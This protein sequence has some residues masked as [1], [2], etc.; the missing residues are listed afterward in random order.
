MGAT[1]ETTIAQALKHEALRE[2]LLD[3]IRSRRFRTGDLFM[4]QNEIAKD[5][6]V[7]QT[8]VVRALDALRKE[9]YLR[10]R[11]GRGT[12]VAHPKSEAGKLHSMLFVGED[13]NVI[14][15]RD[16]FAVAINHLLGWAGRNGVEV[17]YVQVK[18][19]RRKRMNLPDVTGFDG[20]V[21]LGGCFGIPWLLR[22]QTD[23]AIVVVRPDALNL[24][25]RFDC[26]DRDYLG[27]PRAVLAHLADCG[28]DR[29]GIVT[30]RRLKL[31]NHLRMQ[32]TFAAVSEFQ[33]LVKP[34]WIVRGDFEGEKAYVGARDL[35]R[36][37]DRPCAIFALGDEM[38]AGVLRAANELGLSVPDD[39][40]VAGFDGLE[41]SGHLS[42]PLTCYC[43]D[44][45]A[46][47]KKTADLLRF[48]LEHPDAQPKYEPV[49]GRML[50]RQSTCAPVMTAEPVATQ[51]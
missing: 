1:T 42:P 51:R 50:I 38:A 49:P 25:D 48:R 30:G 24:L 46:L 14:V 4:S 21:V 2:S 11:K 18:P 26:V 43:T 45:E 44:P 6:N 19:D 17:Q 16:M 13:R 33:M 36:R 41:Y 31:S 10:S 9:G 47:A 28:Y 40:A 12:F 22:E 15:E 7:S 3:L 8:T 39:V 34:E 29:I 27:G 37:K 35:L 20:I 5:F 32:G 23:A